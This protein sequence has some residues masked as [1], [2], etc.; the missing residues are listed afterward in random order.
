[1]SKNAKVAKKLLNA[2]AIK[3]NT[4]YFAACDN[5]VN[6]VAICKHVPT[7][8]D[9]YEFLPFA[10]DKNLLYSYKEG[11]TTTE[12]YCKEYNLMLLEYDCCTIVEQMLELFGNNI[13]LLCYEKP[14]KFCHRRLAAKWIESELG[15]VVPELGYAEPRKLF[16]QSKL[17]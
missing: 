9:G 3:I 14:S 12:E 17:R 15:L 4:S 1:M 6:P 10:P 11:R 7:W 8:Y 2:D 13:T 5:I 16:L